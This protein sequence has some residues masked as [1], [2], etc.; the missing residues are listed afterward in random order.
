MIFS[1]LR[2]DNAFLSRDEMQTGK[3]SS[4]GWKGN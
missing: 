2:A 1:M 3:Y 4:T